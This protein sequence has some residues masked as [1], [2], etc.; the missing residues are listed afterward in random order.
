MLWNITTVKYGTLVYDPNAWTLGETFDLARLAGLTLADIDE[1]L[2]PQRPDVWRFIWY[3]TLTRAGHDPGPYSEI[4]FSWRDLEI[5]RVL[6]D[7]EQAIMDRMIAEAKAKTEGGVP[8][9]EGPH[10]LEE[11]ST[12]TTGDPTL[13][14]SPSSTSP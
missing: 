3:I 4:D 5:E 11:E 2:I 10:G 1:G 9:D 13:E 8:T 6:D 14:L 12:P 7:D